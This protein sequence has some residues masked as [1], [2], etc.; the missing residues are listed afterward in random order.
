[1]AAE[2]LRCVL[3]MY[4]LNENVDGQRWT[5]TCKYGNLLNISAHPDAWQDVGFRAYSRYVPLVNLSFCP[6]Y[7][8]FMCFSR[9]ALPPLPSGAHTPVPLPLHA[10]CFCL[11]CTPPT[12]QLPRS[13]REHVFRRMLCLGECGMPM[14]RKFTVLSRLV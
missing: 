8:L 13:L 14:R 3:P 2:F 4:L 11:R 10:S 5:T 6:D 7:S 12:P 9:R 1:M